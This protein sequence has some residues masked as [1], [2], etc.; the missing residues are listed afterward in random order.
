MKQ[1]KEIDL[2]LLA[3]SYKDIYYMTDMKEE[4]Q[5]L[6]REDKLSETEKQ[7]LNQLRKAL[8][9]EYNRLLLHFKIS[10]GLY[11][12]E[13]KKDIIYRYLVKKTGI[14]KRIAGPALTDYVQ[15]TLDTSVWDSD[16]K[17][18]DF[19][20]EK[21]LYVLHNALE[22]LGYEKYNEWIRGSHIL[23]SLCS[24][25]YNKDSDLDCH[26]IVDLDAFM[27]CEKIEKDNH[28]IAVT[29]LSDVIKYLNI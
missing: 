6:E 12:T 29:K 3:K 13:I 1:R 17:L 7:R 4:R 15:P 14:L 25:Q 22:K 19:H 11:P 20:K 27:E 5:L 18:F 21:I 8:R 23:G 10:W 26:F 16:S 24:Y 2:Q 9:Q 28:D